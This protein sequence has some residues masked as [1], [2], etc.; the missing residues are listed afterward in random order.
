[1]PIGLD[2][3]GVEDGIEIRAEH[4]DRRAE[5]MTRRRLQQKDGERIR[6][7]SRSRNPH[8][9]GFA[10]VVVLEQFRYDALGDLLERFA[11]AGERRYRISRSPSNACA[12]AASSLV[13]C[14]IRSGRR[15]S[16]RS[17]GANGYRRSE[18]G[19]K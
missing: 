14:N 19:I 12:S 1:L 4:L 18:G 16:G 15:L 11:F 8:P 17:H 7:W 9:D 6:L 3:P 10:R 5:W 13:T 2:L